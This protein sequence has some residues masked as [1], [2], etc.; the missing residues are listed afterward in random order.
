MTFD[1]EV[2]YA[3]GVDVPS[4]GGRKAGTNIGTGRVECSKTLDVVGNNGVRSRGVRVEAA[5]GRDG[6]VMGASGVTRGE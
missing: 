6:V 2:G 5:I 1:S 3:V 4:G